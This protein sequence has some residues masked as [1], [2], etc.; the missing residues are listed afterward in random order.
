M[1]KT[2][3]P[4][5]HCPRRRLS[6]SQSHILSVSDSTNST[7]RSVVDFVSRL[8]EIPEPF[9]VELDNV[10]PGHMPSG[11]VAGF[12]AVNQLP[13]LNALVG[14]TTRLNPTISTGF[15]RVTPIG[16]K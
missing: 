7:M 15:A 14:E 1:P 3:R 11:W 2:Q 4:G 10:Y 12:L 6:P 16:G 5:P 8:S 9:A 13:V